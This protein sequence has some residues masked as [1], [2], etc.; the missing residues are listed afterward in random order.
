LSSPAADIHAYSLHQDADKYY[1]K[2]GSVPIPQPPRIIDFLIQRNA[3]H[4][5]NPASFKGLEMPIV[6]ML[7]EIMREDEKAQKKE[8]RA[9][10]QKDRVYYPHEHKARL[11][12]KIKEYVQKKL[13]N[14]LL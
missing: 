10:G 12:V 13:I 7:V 6:K 9:S 3:L 14:G 4:A 5:D 11:E 8:W 2:D 1:Q